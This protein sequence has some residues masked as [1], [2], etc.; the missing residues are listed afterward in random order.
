MPLI[1][2]PMLVLTH[3]K[4]KLP[5]ARSTH[6]AGPTLCGVLLSA[7][8]LLCGAVAGQRLI[9]PLARTA[10]HSRSHAP[11]S[12][13]RAG[14]SPRLASANIHHASERSTLKVSGDAIDRAFNVLDNR[15]AWV[16]GR[17]ARRHRRNAQQQQPRPRSQ[18]PAFTHRG[19]PAHVVRLRWRPW[20]R[21]RGAPT[22]AAAAASARV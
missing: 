2:Q 9:L 20:W 22:A 12:R 5:I 21:R 15:R 8:G 1:T 19:R 11:P 18:Q 10:A 6:T 4:T 14:A 13:V 16:R 3:L 7:T 17:L